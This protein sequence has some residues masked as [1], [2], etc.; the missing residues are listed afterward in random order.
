VIEEGLHVDR[1]VGGR[2]SAH[3]V[4]AVTNECVVVVM[5]CRW[6][7]EGYRQPALLLWMGTDRRSA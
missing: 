4:P 5:V 1:E 2:A 3:M 7:M 6:R